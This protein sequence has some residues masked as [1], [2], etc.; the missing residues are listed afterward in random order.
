MTVA[1]ARIAFRLHGEA[2]E[3]AATAK[4][5]ARIAQRAGSASTVALAWSAL[6][7]GPDKLLDPLRGRA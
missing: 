7:T 5:L 1:Q 3:A 4:A 6:A 2:G